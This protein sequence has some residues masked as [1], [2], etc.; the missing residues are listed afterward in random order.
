MIGAL[1]QAV[2][3]GRAVP[4]ICMVTKIPEVL[5]GRFFNRS[6]AM[7]I[8]KINIVLRFRALAALRRSR[9]R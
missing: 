6:S 9:R 7:A 5:D 4:S 1:V 2:C 3:R 8:W